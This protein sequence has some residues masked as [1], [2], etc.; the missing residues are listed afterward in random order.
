MDLYTLRSNSQGA[1]SEPRIHPQTHTHAFT[2]A[3]K[4]IVLLLF[5]A[6]RARGKYYYS[7]Q[8]LKRVRKMYPIYDL[9]FCVL[10][11]DF[12][13]HMLIYTTRNLVGSEIF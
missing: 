9:L 5:I 12:C 10:S 13:R 2:Q 11:A 1:R 7:Q 6:L 4:N 8:V 3:D